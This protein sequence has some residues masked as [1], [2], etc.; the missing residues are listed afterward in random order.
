MT[1]PDEPAERRPR[2]PLDPDRNVTYT[3]AVGIRALRCGACGALVDDDP[4]HVGTDD[5]NTYHAIV[6]ETIDGLA[7]RLA[8]LEEALAET[9]ERL[10]A[11]AVRALAP[12][13]A[14]W[15]APIDGMVE[16]IIADLAI[17]PGHVRIIIE[18]PRDQVGPAVDG[19]G[20]LVP[21]ESAAP[22][23]R[24][25]TPPTSET[26][27]YVLEV[28]EIRGQVN[29]FTAALA[30]VNR[31]PARTPTPELPAGENDA[32]AEQRGSGIVR[33]R[34]EGDPDDVDLTLELAESTGFPLADVSIPYANRKGI[35]GNVRR[36]GVVNL[37][38]DQPAQA[39]THMR[40]T[41][42]ADTPPAALCDGSTAATLTGRI[43]LVT[44][45]ACR[46]ETYRII[47]EDEAMRR[48]AEAEA[49]E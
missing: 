28:D 5:H 37:A 31:S 16:A 35:R 4:R 47:A 17:P 8:Q 44:C 40:H 20:K 11:R 43:E 39:E 38:G 24:D 27:V 33:V 49:G 42:G 9:G 13:P 36:Y 34:L 23:M 46:T 12:P 41:V 1:H 21:L 32:E 19:L 26:R 10:D 3:P 25:S 30:A 15:G 18:G 2:F 7:V 6:G 48:Q 22:I 14:I 29:R 45:G